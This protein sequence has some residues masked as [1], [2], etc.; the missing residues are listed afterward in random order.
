MDVRDV[1]RQISYVPQD[2]F[3]F[4]DTISGNIRFGLDKATEEMVRTAARQSSIDKEIMRFPEGYNT[5]VGERGVTLSGD[6]QR[7]L[8]QG[9]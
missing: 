6:K 4:S 8:L 5:L 9:L 2:V 1:R 7:S 3:L